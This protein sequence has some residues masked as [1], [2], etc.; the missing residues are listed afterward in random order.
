MMRYTQDKFYAT[1]RA[2]IGADFWGKPETYGETSGVL[3]FWDT[4]GQG[5]L[6]TRCWRLVS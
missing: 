4:A 6:F 5:T 2:T 1:Y 3:Q